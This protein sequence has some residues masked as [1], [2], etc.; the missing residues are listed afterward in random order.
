LAWFYDDDEAK[1]GSML[2]TDQSF[3]FCRGADRYL[4]AGSSP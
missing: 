3:I 2:M 4:V 1:C